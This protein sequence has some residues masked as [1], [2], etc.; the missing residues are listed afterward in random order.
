MLIYSDIVAIWGNSWLKCTANIIS[1]HS[2]S[3]THWANV[4]IFWAGLRSEGS[5][6]QSNNH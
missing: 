1:E 3:T 5:Q 2:S 6:V 4:Y